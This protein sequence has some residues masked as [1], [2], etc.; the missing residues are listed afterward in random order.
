[1]KRYPGLRRFVL[2]L[3]LGPALAHAAGEICLNGEGWTFQPVKVPFYGYE[4]DA[5]GRWEPVQRSHRFIVE[6]I[7]DAGNDWRRVPVRVPM[8]WS[9]ATS[10]PGKRDAT[11]DFAFPWFWQFVHR[12][13]Y[14]RNFDVPASFAGQRVK[15]QCESVNFRCWI[16]V[17]DVLVRAA[18]A[19]GDFTHEN[20]HPFEVDLTDCVRAPSRGNRLRIVVHDFT[21]SFAGSF[22]NEDDP[23]NGI[24]YPLGD[25]CDYYNKDRGWRNIDSGIVGDVVLAAVAP[26]H[27][28]EV[29]V[30]TSVRD[31]TI[32]ADFLVRNESASARTVRVRARV[33]AAAGDEVP[34][35]FA[36]TP[37][38]TLPA[39]E[40]RAVSLRQA[41]SHPRLW[42][43]H[44][45][46]LHRLIIDLEEGGR[47]VSSQPERFGFREVEMRSDADRDRRGFYLNGV[48]TRLFG[49]SVEPTWK[50]GYTEGVGTSGLYLYNPA[51]WSA[52]IDE[53]KR[54]NITVLR[55]HRGMWTSRMFEIAD[56]K[57]MMMIAESTVNNGNHK[58]GN[59]TSANQR[60][61]IGDLISSLRNHP[62]IVIWSL[63]NESPYDEAWAEEAHRHDQTRPL[64][65]TQTQPRNHPSPSLAVATGSYAMGLNGYEPSIYGRHD[66]A[67]GPKPMYI[68]EDNA[69]YDQPADGERLGAVQ[70]GLTI[71]RGHR[72]TGYEIICTFY[73]WQKLYGQPQPPE[74][75]LLPIH[76]T[77]AQTSA[78]GYHPDFARM[79]LL[80]PWTD[81]P[82]PRVLRRLAPAAAVPPDEF[83][84][85][86][87]SPV[88]VF[89]R[90]YDQRTD[91]AANPYV[92]PLVSAR[93]LTVHNDDLKDRSTRIEVMWSVSDFAGGAAISEGRA[94]VEVPLGGTRSLPITLDAKG[95]VVVQ[96][97]Y[98]AFKSG[99]ECFRE[100][101]YLRGT[102]ALAPVARMGAVSGSASQTAAKTSDDTVLMSAAADEVQATGY[103]R[104]PFPAS[105]AGVA[106]AA[107]PAGAGDWVQFNPE[108]RVAGDYDV[109]LQVPPDVRG[110]QAVEILHD[111][112]NVTSEVDLAPGGWVRLTA[113]PLRMQPGRL[114]NAVRILG[115]D[116]AGRS[117]ILGIKLVRAQ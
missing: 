66:A 34:L 86:S 51:Y 21:A 57:G 28:A 3:L 63:A 91:V 96:V 49:E 15:L 104:I 100:T 47:T 69:C 44:D 90:E 48:R 102:P 98:R 82:A 115:R 65:A 45:P 56:E 50:D 26:V 9:C 54:L 32:A 83:W 105:P 68:Y 31:S 73:T 77:A 111:S 67:W 30:R 62:S 88:A 95:L 33:V 71:F 87:F 5:P 93:T 55:T 114:Q 40:A 58:G 22:P 38:L 4:V 92:A 37:E 60:R 7:Q 2:L 75:R 6:A 116:G 24:D 12:G 52:L 17:N 103:R 113:A 108:V 84:R 109:Y 117:V 43:P 13:V 78:R 64:V 25:R 29:A 36:E 10:D 16:Y 59:G 70:K 110:R 107:D 41:W 97:T 27:V 106:Y 81:P 20:K 42:W 74:Q 80:D 72:S 76:W 46:F 94:S 35:R 89:D 1:M 101:I 61:A 39:G 18:D 99:K 85:R 53:A 19:A 14:E 23:V 112:I 79:P 11:G 8:A